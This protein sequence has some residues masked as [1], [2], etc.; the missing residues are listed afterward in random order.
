MNTNAIAQSGYATEAYDKTQKNQ[1]TSKVTTGLT[2]GEPELSEK[3]QKYYEQLKSKF[4]NMDFV[5]VSA[6]KKEEA[7][8]NAAQYANANRMVVLIDTEKIERM[9]EDEAYRKQYEGIISNAQTQLA[10]VKNSLGSNAS[11]VK[12]YGMEFNKKGLASFFAV[13][14]KSQASQKKRI[15]KR[16]EKR[17]EEKKT[18]KKEAEKKRVEKRKEAKAE[19]TKE[20][21]KKRDTEQNE[22]YVTVRASSI[23]ELMQKINDVLY[24]GMSDYV[25]TPEE[26]LLGR[27]INFSA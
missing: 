14:D 12:T 23:E 19:K 10:Q 6:D 21:E 24:E 26:Q 27:H 11:A 22:D 7:K 18:A 9:A 13:V 25:E 4:S 3:A 20:A 1:K 8:A 15:E 17:A 5:L 16:A 2:V